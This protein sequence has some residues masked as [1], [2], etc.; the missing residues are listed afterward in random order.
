[1]HPDNVPDR[2]LTAARAACARHAEKV[3]ARFDAARLAGD[4]LRPGLPQC[5]IAA[6]LSRG[7]Q[8]KVHRPASDVRASIDQLLERLARRFT[9]AGE[10]ELARIASQLPKYP[11][12]VFIERL[13]EMLHAMDRTGDERAEVREVGL[14][15]IVPQR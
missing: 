11:D 9:A 3:L 15:L 2:V 1:M 12:S 10:R 7:L 14:L 5:R 8:S 4:A 13:L 6:W